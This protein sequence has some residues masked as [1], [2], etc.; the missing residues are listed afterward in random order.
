MKTL[1]ASWVIVA[2]NKQVYYS[3]DSGYHIHYKNIG[4]CFGP[5]LGVSRF[6]RKASCSRAWE[7]VYPVIA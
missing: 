1:W 2:D 6:E 4:D 5:Y 7:H 3:G